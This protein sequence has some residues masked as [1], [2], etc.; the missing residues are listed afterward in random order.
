MPMR[1]LLDAAQALLLRAATVALIAALLPLQAQAQFR[2]VLVFGDASLRNA[3][4]EANNLF[5]F[6]NGS[7]IVVS[8]GPSAALAKQIE[9]GAAA[10]VFISADQQSMDYVAERKLIKADTRTKFL[11]NSVVLVA[12]ADSKVTLTIGQNF[13]LAQALGGG[14][15]AL[16]DPASGLAGRYGKAALEALGA[17]APVASRIAPA[18][19]ARTVL[20]AV[21]RGEAALGIVLQSEAVAD[22]NVKVVAAFPESTHPPIIYPMAIL[23]NSTNG[24]APV[25]L[26]YLLSPKAEPFFEKQGFIVY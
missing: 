14:R 7:G 16:P 3:L 24:V 9:T 19:D 26:Q 23:T 22:K 18:Q 17:W 12:R 15:L 20:L 25:Y 13:P 21:S 8:Y 1:A 11:G 6:E 4:E 2:D 10:D 5:R